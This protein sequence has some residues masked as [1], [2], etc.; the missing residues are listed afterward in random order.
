ML[1][2]NFELLVANRVAAKD[3]M[4]LAMSRRP[5]TA[6]DVDRKISEYKDP[7]NVSRVAYQGFLLSWLER[8]RKAMR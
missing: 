7:A 6:A 5:W 2:L 1:N 4:I 8:R 3:A